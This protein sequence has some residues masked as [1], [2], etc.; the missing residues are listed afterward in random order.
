M[1]NEFFFSALQLRRDSLGATPNMNRQAS[2]LALVCCA[3][4]T[5][6]RGSLYAQS[7]SLRA[8]RCF[9]VEYP[10]WGPSRVIGSPIG[11]AKAP[12][13]LVLM[14]G[15]AERGV[16]LSAAVGSFAA[17]AIRNEGDSGSY[18]AYWRRQSA[19]SDSLSITFPIH[20]GFYGLEYRVRERGDTLAGE[21]TSWTDV[22]GVRQARSRIV[23]QRARCS[24][25][26]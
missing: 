6:S 10:D 20:I 24:R 22:L 4:C 26:A 25:G 23:A 9:R 19:T 2:L 12:Q 3:G 16:D 11:Q 14:S 5:V 15:P 17:K 13:I 21:V 8:P 7:D 18:P 1:W